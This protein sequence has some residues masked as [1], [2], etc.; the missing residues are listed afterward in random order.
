MNIL[1]TGIAGFAGSKIASGLI[2]IHPSIEIIGLDNFSRKGSELNISELTSLR[3]DLIRGDIR[4]QSDIDDLPK[5]A[6]TDR[7]CSKSI[8]TCRFG[9][10]FFKQASNETQSLRHN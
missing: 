6:S 7:L 8:R 4:S 9:R 2:S 10:V 3:I 1:I 5:P